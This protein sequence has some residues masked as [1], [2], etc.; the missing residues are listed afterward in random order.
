[1]SIIPESSIEEIRSI[2]DIV[3]VVGEYVQL[4]KRSSNFVG[5]C[6]FHSEKTPSFNVNPRLGIF[7]CFGCGEGGDVFSF[8]SRMESLSFPEAVRVLSDRVGV[9]LPEE[10][11]PGDEAS[12]GESI[13]HALRFAARFFHGRLAKDP[14]AQT[15]RDYLQNRGFTRE[16]A[17]KFGI[18][19]AP[20][21]WDSLLTE[22]SEQHVAVDFLEKA[23]LVIARK[24]ET[25][26]YDRYRH[27]L[28]FPIFSHVGKVIG[29]GGRI[30]REDDQPKYINS[31]E[32]K[33]YSKVRVLYGLY[34][35]KNAIRGKEEA[36]LVEG[37]TDVVSLHQAGVQNVVASSGTALTKDQI[38]AL[39]RYCKVIIL[40]YD[41]DSAGLRAALR[42]IDLIL[43][44]GLIPYAV[45]L[46]DGEDPDSYVQQNG[47]AAFEAFLRDHRQNFIQ[48]VLANAKAA[49]RMDSP[50][51]IASVQR[52]ILQSVARISD[53]L[54]REAYLR[55]A[56]VSL[57][58]PDN[59]LRPIVD[60]YRRGEKHSRRVP[61]K[62]AQ[63]V[64]ESSKG[65]ADVDF[66]LPAI[67]E[68]PHLAEK[69]LLRLMLED[70]AEMIEWVMSR[71]A[72]TD[73]TGGPSREFATEL[74]KQYS[75]NRFNRTSFLSPATPSSIRLLAA[76]VMTTTD[77]PSDNWGKK[78]I[79]VP[80]LDED[81]IK[82][83]AS[84]MRYLKKHRLD[85]QIE[86]VR[87]Q[88]MRAQETGAD[89]RELQMKLSKLYQ[90]GKH[91]ES[92]R[93]LTDSIE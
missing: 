50:E 58:I 89:P 9:V 67:S 28:I 92:G 77:E 12:E 86:K 20:D 41:A 22:A 52:T 73:F 79:L 34:Q 69:K 72:L 65:E 51:G 38:G 14:A 71:M 17:K 19:Y 47:A 70:G 74:V 59:D 31:P 26:Y 56:A 13:Y 15:A 4:K 84:S 30:L 68:K 23:G 81:A 35:S 25:G 43:E 27:R 16:S 64:K 39:S 1:M 57:D 5:L 66:D 54:N 2:V 40:L 7:K 18:G 78:L 87:M 63:A 48:F 88:V 29:F 33:V 8:V 90:L 36:I 60:A 3:D 85:Q 46:P 32:T 11:V 91:I 42:G 61:I 76:E 37:Y 82:S 53:P 55:S 44:E 10:E 75:E 83:A 49:G 21:E 45:R 80:R 93:F 62:S 6:P 24:E